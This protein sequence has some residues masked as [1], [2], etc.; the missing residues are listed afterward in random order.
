MNKTKQNCLSRSPGIFVRR[1]TIFPLLLLS[2]IL[3][4]PGVALSSPPE[5]LKPTAASWTLTGSLGTARDLHTE[6]LLPSGKI[7]VAGGVA[8]HTIYLNG[9]ELYDPITGIWTPTGS[10]GTARHLH[11]ATL[12]P[13]NDVLGGGRTQRSSL[14]QR[15]TV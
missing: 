9:A 10:L 7:L 6:T 5:Y 15:G 14:E 4:R 8:P 12:L 1:V 2:A 3:W 11:T 13:S